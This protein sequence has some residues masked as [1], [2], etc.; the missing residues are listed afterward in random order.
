MLRV[1]IILI[2]LSFQMLFSSENLI[3]YDINTN[4]YPKIEFKSFSRINNEIQKINKND[5]KLVENQS[6]IDDFSVFN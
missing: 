4:Q 3:I 5:Y 1:L 2:L 6:E